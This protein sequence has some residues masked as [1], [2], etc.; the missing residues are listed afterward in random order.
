MKCYVYIFL[1]LCNLF[2]FRLVPWAYGEM[3]LSTGVRYDMFTDD[4]SPETLGYEITFPIGLA[5]RRE[6]FVLALETGSIRR[7]L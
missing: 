4:R 7:V 5:W 6:R 3:A 1:I 2:S